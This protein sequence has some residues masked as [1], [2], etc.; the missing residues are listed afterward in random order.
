[1]S[2][3][4]SNLEIDVDH[5]FVTRAGKLVHLTRTEWQLLR[6]L[7]ANPGRVLRSRDLLT[8]V[9]G[10]EYQDDLQYL[11]VWVS[12][13]RKK[14]EDDPGRPQLI[15]TKQGIGYLFDVPSRSRDSIAS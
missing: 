2:I 11:R 5:R 4:V 14:L 3:N 12:R 8:N 15:K 10:V 13:L 9:W 7:T 1:V 6:Y